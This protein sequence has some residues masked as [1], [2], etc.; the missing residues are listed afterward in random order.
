MEYLEQL[1]PVYILC[2]NLLIF[3]HSIPYVRGICFSI[4][5]ANKVKSLIFTPGK[6]TR[7]MCRGYFTANRKWKFRGSSEIRARANFIPR[8]KKRP[9]TCRTQFYSNDDNRI[10]NYGDLRPNL[11]VKR[12]R[13]LV[14][15]NCRS[16]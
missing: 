3:F 9:I 8:I 16:E 15:R 4:S 11:R 14:I 7:V 13:T 2:Y 10:R 12:G 1:Q 6:N 5:Y